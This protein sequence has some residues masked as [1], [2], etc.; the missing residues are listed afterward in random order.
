V[1]KNKG[2]IIAFL[3]GAAFGRAVFREAGRLLNLAT[4][5]KESTR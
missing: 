4:F 3:L 2:Y 5:G 1:K